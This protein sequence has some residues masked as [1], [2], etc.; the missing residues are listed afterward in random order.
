MKANELRIGNWIAQAHAKIQV[1]K[2]LENFVVCTDHNGHISDCKYENIDPIPLEPELLERC[3]FVKEPPR[4][5]TIDLGKG[6]NGM[7]A[8]CI[9]FTDCGEILFQQVVGGGFYQGVDVPVTSLHQIQ[10]LYHAITGNELE[11]KM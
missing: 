10:N 6:I 5:Y 8:V 1:T 3:G 2:I 7:L 9:C 11:V 4:H